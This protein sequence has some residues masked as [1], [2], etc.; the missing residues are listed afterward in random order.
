MA[1]YRYFG[2]I[3]IFGGH[4]GFMQIKHS[5]NQIARYFKRIIGCINH[6]LELKITQ[7]YLLGAKIWQNIDIWRP[8][9]I[10]AN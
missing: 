5:S 1:K 7:I 2:K 9:W 3:S 6:G 4:L 10:Y 8:S